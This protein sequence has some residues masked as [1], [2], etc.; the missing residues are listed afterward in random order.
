ME[1]SSW[2]ILMK[3]PE[4]GVNE[5]ANQTWI[6][7]SC[8]EPWGT[9]TTKTL[10]R[11]FMA[12]G[13]HTSLTFMVWHRHAN[14]TQANTIT[15]IRLDHTNINP[16]C[17]FYPP[18]HTIIMRLSISILTWREGQETGRPLSFLQDTIGVRL[19][20]LPA[21][22]CRL[23]IPLQSVLIITEVIS[24]TTPKKHHYSQQ[25]MNGWGSE[26]WG[27]RTSVLL[28]SFDLNVA[29]FL[30]FCVTFPGTIYIVYTDS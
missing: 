17:L 13:M 27:L 10:W 21:P 23:F 22:L 19:R 29:I 4:D 6:M 16:S 30:S 12:R 1:S 20:A 18:L 26:G 15:S 3:W 25:W 11:R 14:Q 9:T 2:Q 28:F 7:T 24:V 8:R 5:R